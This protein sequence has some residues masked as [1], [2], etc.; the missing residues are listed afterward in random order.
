M[1][2]EIKLDCELNPRRELVCKFPEDKREEP[3]EVVDLDPMADCTA[4]LI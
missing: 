4:L 1:M 3:N 2:V